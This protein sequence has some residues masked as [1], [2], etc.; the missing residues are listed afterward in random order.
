MELYT[1]RH[2]MRKPKEKTYIISIESYK[3]LLNVC[4]KYSMNLAWKYPCSCNFCKKTI[5]L[6]RKMLDTALKYEI[7]D[8]FRDDGIIAVP[9]SI[10]NIFENKEVCD[11]Y[12]QYALLDYIEYVAYYCKEYEIR[13]E[14]DCNHQYYDFETSD[15]AYKVFQKE[16]NDIFELVGL[17]YVLNDEKQIER[18][19]E[20]TPL[21]QEIENNISQI[22][23]DETRKLLQEAISLYKSPYPNAARDAAERIWD[24]FERLKTYYITLD[25]R[26]SVEKIVNDMSNAQQPFIDLF[27]AEFKTLTDI[28]N[29]FRIR[30]HETDKIDITDSRHYDYFF[31]RCLSLI[32][33][34]IQYLE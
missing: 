30:H 23:E 11:D 8:L 26:H 22:N 3:L 16:I 21:T 33:L 9:K 31:N 20:Y 24:A 4:Q 27:N 5:N 15:K 19:M 6:N 7:P 1:Q 18:I 10:F 34:A 12:N 28:G 32:A 14:I 2:G 29:K 17:L 25:K 13:T